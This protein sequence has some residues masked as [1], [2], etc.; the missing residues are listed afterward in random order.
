MGK[1]KRC[2][3]KSGISF[4]LLPLKIP[5]NLAAENNTNLLFYSLVGQKSHTSL[6]GLKSFWR[7]YIYSHVEARGGEFAF[8]L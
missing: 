4:L 2:A 5:T 6:T 3:Q 1:S 8:S 7:H